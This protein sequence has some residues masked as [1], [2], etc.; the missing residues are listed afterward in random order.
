MSEFPMKL[1]HDDHHVCV[2]ETAQQA[3]DYAVKEMDGELEAVDPVKAWEAYP[4]DFLFTDYDDGGTTR[5]A[6]AWCLENG[7]GY[8]TSLDY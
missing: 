5:T 8:F 4:D 7:P 1:W 3:Y 6:A 2:A